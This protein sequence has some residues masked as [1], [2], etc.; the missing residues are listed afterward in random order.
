MIFSGLGLGFVTLSWI[1]YLA[2]IPT[3]QVPE[4]PH[5]HIVL[6]LLGMGL[7]AIG[8]SSLTIAS[9]ATAVVAWSLGVFFLYLLSI[10]AL[11]DGELTVAI[12]DPLP[13]FSAPDHT[14]QIVTSNDWRGQRMLLK[15]FRGQW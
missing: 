1:W 6:M 5:I 3:E 14:G 13:A 8:A 7:A 2:L 10:A 9:V 12:G 4:R 15:F 11:P